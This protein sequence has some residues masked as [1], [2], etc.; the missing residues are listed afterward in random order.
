M[1]FLNPYYL[2]THFHHD[3]RIKVGTNELKG[4]HETM[5]NLGKQIADKELKLSTLEGDLRIERE[6][7]QSLQESDVK[8]K[9]EI[10]K[11]NMEIQKLQLLKNVCRFNSIFKIVAYYAMQY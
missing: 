9:E 10:C 3:K 11:L 6:W 7:R 8:D 2:S 5:R 1:F 4:S